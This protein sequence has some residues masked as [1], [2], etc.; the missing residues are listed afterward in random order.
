MY[1]SAGKRG[2][3]EARNAL[4]GSHIW[5]QDTDYILPPHHW[6]PSCSPTLTP[7]NRLYVPGAGG[8]VYSRDNADSS[9]SATGRLAFFGLSAYL[10]DPTGFNSTVFID[11]PI[12][13]DS[14]GNIYFGFRT[15]GSAPLGLQSGVARIDASGNGIWISAADVLGGATNITRVPHQ[16]APALSNDEQTLLRGRGKPEHR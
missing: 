13:A 7:T 3:V 2:K 16:A 5:S 10:A 14:A 12:T 6:T 8:T 9:D 1:G 11:I 15:N 4:D